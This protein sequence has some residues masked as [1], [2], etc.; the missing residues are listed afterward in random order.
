M[1]SR[2][3]ELIEEEVERRINERLLKII[4]SIAKTY[5]I[6]SKQLMK[7]VRLVDKSIPETCMGF[8]NKRTKCK[9][10]YC[11]D[12]KNGYCKKHQNQVPKRKTNEPIT[13]GHTHDAS[14]MYQQGCPVCDATRTVKVS[15]DI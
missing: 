12:A 14:I 6:S 9:M 13:S 2:I 7:D 5:D 8:T 1:E 15:I 4:D 3:A 10:G 11:K